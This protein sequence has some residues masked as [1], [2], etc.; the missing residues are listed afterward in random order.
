MSERNTLQ[1]I[2]QKSTR[3]TQKRARQ[4]KKRKKNRWDKQEA[5]TKMMT[6]I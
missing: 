2:A 6:Q 5:N 4:R 3:L 1:P